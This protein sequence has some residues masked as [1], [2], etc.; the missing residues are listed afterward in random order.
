MNF[1]NEGHQLAVK[2]P[3]C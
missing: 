2:M 1:E 3:L